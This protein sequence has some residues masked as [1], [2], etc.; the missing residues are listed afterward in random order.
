M[1]GRDR[2]NKMERNGPRIIRAADLD[3]RTGPHSRI[4]RDSVGTGGVTEAF[5]TLFLLSLVPQKA[6]SEINHK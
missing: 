4:W 2:E 6:N 1:A 5:R 3:E